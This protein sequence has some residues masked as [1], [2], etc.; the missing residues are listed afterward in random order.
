LIV[1]YGLKNDGA[2]IISTRLASLKSPIP[3]GISL[4]KTNNSETVSVEAGVADYLKVYQT[5][6]DK[7][8]GDYFTINISCPNAYGGLPFTDPARLEKLLIEFSKIPKQKPLFLKMPPD[9][10]QTDLDQ[11]IDLA[12]KYKIDGFIATNLTKDKNHPTVVAHLKELLPTDKGGL[13]GKAVAELSSSQVA[14]LANRNNG[15]FIIIA[16][17]GIFTA[18]DAYR[19]IRA[20]AQ[21]VQIATGMIFGGP[22]TIGQ[23]NHGLVKLLRRDGFSSISEAVGADL[24]I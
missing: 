23:I 15:R 21:L 24:K 18:A 2:A 19:Q 11:I 17:G 16:C 9:I 8:V 3:L 14:Y 13:S 10:S 22:Q 6:L 20:G 12:A 1:Y 4:A 5:F 7:K